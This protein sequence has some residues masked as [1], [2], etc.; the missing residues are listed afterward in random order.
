MKDKTGTP[1][2][3]PTKGGVYT[4][5]Y[6]DEQ[7]QYQRE[8]VNFLKSDGK[9]EGTRKS[10]FYEE[11]VTSWFYCDITVPSESMRKAYRLL[12]KE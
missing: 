5:Q 1:L 10:S 6:I 11:N 12:G 7:G 9:W 4:I 8:V 3:Y 2:G